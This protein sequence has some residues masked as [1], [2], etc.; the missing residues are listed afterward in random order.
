[1]KKYNKILLVDDN[2]TIN[3]YNE[4]IVEETDFF[5]EI[6]VIDNGTDAIK[7]FKETNPSDFPDLVLLDI[8]MPDY[9]GFE[10]LDEIEEEE[11]EE[12]ENVKVA[13][14]TTSQHKR[15]LEKYK[16]YTNIIA[17]IEKPLTE[18]TLKKLIKEKLS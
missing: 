14:L 8:K 11:I 4:D 2:D 6:I 16:R 17:F 12:F 13:I 9:D 1:M 5:K 7:Y 3:F 15:D 10:V 18:Q